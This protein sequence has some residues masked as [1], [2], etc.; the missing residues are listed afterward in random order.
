M[1]NSTLVKLMRAKSLIFFALQYS[2][3]NKNK[4]RKNRDFMRVDIL[5]FY[6]GSNSG[7]IGSKLGGCSLNSCNRLLF[8]KKAGIPNICLSSLTKYRSF[9]FSIIF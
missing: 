9:I 4:T 7:H 5:I 6:N 2:N 3:L 8:I 1:Q